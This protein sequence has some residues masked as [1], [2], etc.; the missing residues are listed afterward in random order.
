MKKCLTKRSTA[1]KTIFGKETSVVQQLTRN[2][3]IT[4]EMEGGVSDFNPDSQILES[5]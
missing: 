5:C 1:R 4:E 2:L 3:K